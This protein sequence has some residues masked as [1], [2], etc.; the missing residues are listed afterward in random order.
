MIYCFTHQ[1]VNLRLLI[2]FNSSFALFVHFL[3]LNKQN[4]KKCFMIYI[5]HSENLYTFQNIKIFLKK[6]A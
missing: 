2:D 4:V 1:Q 5:P 6:S 3:C